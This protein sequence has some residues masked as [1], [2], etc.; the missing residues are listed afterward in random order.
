MSSIRGESSANHVSCLS[1]WQWAKQEFMNSP[2]W[3]DL[4]KSVMSLSIWFLKS[5]SEK[6][7][8]MLQG[9]LIIEMH[10]SCYELFMLVYIPFIKRRLEIFKYEHKFPCTIH[11]RKLK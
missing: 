2:V 8:D 3:D 10:L 5:A 1:D 9:N 4:E 6:R 11:N 7:Y